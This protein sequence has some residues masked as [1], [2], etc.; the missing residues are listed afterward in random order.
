MNGLAQQSGKNFGLYNV[1]ERLTLFTGEAGGIHI[2]S[3]PGE[4]T[5][6][7]IRMPHNKIIEKN[8]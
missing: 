5:K 7:V 8:Q 3:K 4:G 2:M 6:V 1:H